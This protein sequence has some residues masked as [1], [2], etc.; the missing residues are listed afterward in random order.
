MSQRLLPSSS[1][2]CPACMDNAILWRE[3]NSICD[4]RWFP[5]CNKTSTS[6]SV[7]FHIICMCCW[8]HYPANQ[9]LD[10]IWSYVISTRNDRN[11]ICVLRKPISHE[12]NV[13]QMIYENMSI[14]SKTHIIKTEW[15]PC[16]STVF[17][18]C[19][20]GRSEGFTNSWWEILWF[21]IVPS[22]L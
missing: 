8:P 7:H 18:I 9:E 11:N 14:L 22:A 19:F 5:S 3:K 10:Y 4:H 6:N 2:P 21:P 13:A 17:T 16:T 1:I 12:S 15:S 20:R